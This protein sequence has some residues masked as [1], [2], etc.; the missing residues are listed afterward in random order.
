[1]SLVASVCLFTLTDE[2]VILLDVQQ[3]LLSRGRP[4]V[5]YNIH[6]V[7]TKKILIISLKHVHSVK[8]NI[9]FTFL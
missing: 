6:I 2:Y 3:P 7:L 9:A 5:S 4:L 8:I 1:M